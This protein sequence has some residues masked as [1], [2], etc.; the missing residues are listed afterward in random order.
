M[1]IRQSAPRKYSTA[2]FARKHGISLKAALRILA[3]GTGCRDA[4][5]LGRKAARRQS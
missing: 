1:F 2:Y 4:N 5:R 3:M